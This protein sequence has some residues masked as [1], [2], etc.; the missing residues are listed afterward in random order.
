MAQKIC[1]SRIVHEAPSKGKSLPAL[2]RTIY[3]RVYILNQMML[4]G[5]I[6]VTTHYLRLCEIIFL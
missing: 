5:I 4:R 6:Y 2:T 1:Y 3:F